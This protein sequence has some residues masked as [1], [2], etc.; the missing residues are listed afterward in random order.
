MTRNRFELVFRVTHFVDKTHA[1]S[2]KLYRPLLDI[3]KTNCQSV[4]VLEGLIYVEKPY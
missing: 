3:L 2:D 4:C 1:G